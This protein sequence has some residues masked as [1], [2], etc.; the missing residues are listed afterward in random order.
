M[1][2]LM[3][4]GGGISGLTAAFR[5]R[6]AGLDFRLLECAP[7]LGGV[8]RSQ[9]SDEGVREL[10]PDALM[11]GHPA[12]AQLLK[13]L[14]LDQ[15]LVQPASGIPWMARNGR[16]APLPNGFRQIGPTRW[17]PF[18]LTPLLSIW[19]KLRVLADLLLP[20]SQAE[21]QTL[22]QLV[23]RRMGTEFLEQLAQPLVAGIYAADPAQLS[24]EATM[25]HLLQLEKQHG[26]LLRGIWK[27]PPQKPPTMASLPG[28]IGQLISALEEKVGHWALKSTTVGVIEPEGGG[29]T[30][31]STD[32]AWRSRRVLLAVP[33]ADC[34]HLVQGFD[35]TLAGWLGGIYC[36]SVAILNQFY[37]TEQLRKVPPDCP[38]LLLPLKE[39]TSFSAISLAH[40]KWPDRTCPELVNLRV[41]L[42]GAGREHWLDQDD[43]Q[44]VDQITREIRPW[45]GIRGRPLTSQLTRHQGKLPEYRL[46]HK[47]RVRKILH[48]VSN[49][50]GL[51]VTGN[52]LNGVGIAHCIAGADALS[53]DWKV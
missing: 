44:L 15:D 30:V 26:S 23:G 6:Q 40:K 21:D 17:L 51:Q 1:L 13:E 33:S 49:W 11:L 47:S 5:A 20:A 24:L 22:A 8:I 3:I 2:D 9:P 31:T 18:A 41:H 48:R 32:R 34:T 37:F 19:G 25:G 42:G 12:V 45:L 27:S 46:G 29:W 10:G 43:Q 7:Q 35:P 38:G 53:R 50:P 28:G 39:G 36:R 52:W 16:L 14:N 4:I